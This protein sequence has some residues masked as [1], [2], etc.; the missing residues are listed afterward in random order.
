MATLK[1]ICKKSHSQMSCDSNQSMLMFRYTHQAKTTHFFTGKN[2]DPQFLD[3]K[4]Q[5]IKKAFLGYIK[6]NVLLS[7]QRQKIED[8]INSA[9]AN[10]INPTCDYVKNL[11]SDEKATKKAKVE[12]PFWEFV[13]EYLREAKVKLNPNTLRCYNN[14]INNLKGFEAF[15]KTTLNWSSFNL[16]F[17]Y[18]FFDYYTGYKGLGN[19]GFG[20]VIKVLKSILNSATERGLNTYMSYKSK[21]FKALREDV[22]NIYLSEEELARVKNL[23][24]SYSKKLTHVRDLFIIACYTGLRFSDFSKLA[25]ENIIEDRI[26]IRTQKTGTDVIIPVLPDVIEIIEKYEG[27]LPKAY[28]NQKMNEYLKVIMQIAGFDEVIQ[29]SYT[30]G[31]KTIKQ[32]F[33]KWEMIST[34]TARRSFATNMF[35]RGIPSPMI[36]QLTGHSTEK[37]FMTYIKISKEENAMRFLEYFKKSA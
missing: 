35:K 33:R 28:C 12:L 26:K 6:L 29:K 7:V 18:K 20:K 4:N 27:K 19:N 31:N 36:M 15:E 5:C 11:H 32:T 1:L 14:I 24:L 25:P 17:Y 9:L 2:I 23:D 10:D 30:S 37:S 13:E 3:K 21:D 8:I 22:Y 34:H 16:S